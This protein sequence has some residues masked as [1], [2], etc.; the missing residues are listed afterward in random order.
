M[1]GFLNDSKRTSAA[2]YSLNWLSLYGGLC[3]LLAWFCYVVYLVFANSELP[4]GSETLSILT[5]GVVLAGLGWAT[6]RAIL[7]LCARIYS[8]RSSRQRQ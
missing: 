7:H 4:N 1:N 6:V 8:Q 2:R 3:V 5:V